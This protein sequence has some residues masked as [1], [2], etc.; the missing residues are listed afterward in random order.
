[1]DSAP[2][3]KENLYWITIEAL[4]NALKHSQARKIQINIRYTNRQLSLEIKDDG[5]GF[6]LNRMQNG[7]LGMRTMRER[8]ELLGG[9]IN[10]KS[11]PGEGTLVS[12]EAET[13]AWYG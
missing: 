11:S 12:F 9:Q 5:I 2:E 3:W 4:N 1:M 7:G 6:N 13:E 8:A 10:I